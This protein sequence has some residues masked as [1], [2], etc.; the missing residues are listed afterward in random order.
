MSTR[1]SVHRRSNGF[2]LIEL[3]VVI[4]IIAVLVGLLLPAVQKVREAASRMSCQ[5][6]LKQLAL[7][8]HNYHDSNS[9]FPAEYMYLKTAAWTTPNNGL[10]VPWPVSVM[11]YIEQ[12]AVYNGYL[13]MTSTAGYINTSTDPT[14]N[15]LAAV[16][17]TFIC[18]STLM[19]TLYNSK[20]DG[21]G[22]YSS[23]GSYLGIIG[24]GQTAPAEY[25]G[26]FGM[27]NLVPASNVSQGRKVADFT[28]GTSTTLLFGEQPAHNDP[29]YTTVVSMGINAWPYNDQTCM[30]ANAWYYHYASSVDAY[31]GLPI[32]YQVPSTTT[33]WIYPYE[34]SRGGI[35]SNHTGGANF[36]FAD[37]SVHFLSNG[38]STS[39]IGNCTILDAMAT[40]SG[41]EVVPGNS[42]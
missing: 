36:A 39:M 14:V 32:N 19:P 7:A 33:N 16:I 35:G 29:L 1:E 4:A 41:G 18:P 28:D 38:V 23:I 17:K 26:A 3:L 2:T 37:G 8:C 25:N 12:T 9:H 21:T 6:N 5:N 24:Y 15:P 10:F 13:A 11:P 34:F 42:F 31:Y 20:Q 27:T 40:V 22:G 30:S